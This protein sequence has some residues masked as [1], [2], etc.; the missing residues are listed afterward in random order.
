MRAQAARVP[1]Q[2]AA[3]GRRSGCIVQHKVRVH[4]PTMRVHHPAQ[5]QSA[6]SHN[7]GASSEM[8]SGCIIQHKVRVH[9]PTMRVHHAPHVPTRVHPQPHIQDTPFTFCSSESAPFVTFQVH[10]ALQVPMGSAL[11][12]RTSLSRAC[13]RTTKTTAETAY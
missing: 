9:H 4:H 12:N 6:P 10:Q 2:G 7:E 3:S 8:H 11:T 1:T 5:D 13:A